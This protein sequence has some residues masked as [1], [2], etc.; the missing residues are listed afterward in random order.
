MKAKTEHK[1]VMRS[2]A[3]GCER[4][5]DAATSYGGHRHAPTRRYATPRCQKDAR[6]H[7]RRVAAAWD[8]DTAAL[9][10]M[11]ELEERGQLSL[12]P[13]PLPP[14]PDRPERAAS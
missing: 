9:R 5:F 8:R 6:N 1:P 7:I 12:D 4:T 13:T 10:E 2:C 3:C 11:H 14:V